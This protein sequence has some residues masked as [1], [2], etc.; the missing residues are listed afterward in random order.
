MRL[1]KQELE[2]VTGLKGRQIV[3]Y[4]PSARR[5]GQEQDVNYVKMV[6]L[7]ILRE[8]MAQCLHVKGANAVITL[9][10]VQ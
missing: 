4:A 1:E 9:T 8:F 5:E 6:T 2:S 10:L 7:E 3:L